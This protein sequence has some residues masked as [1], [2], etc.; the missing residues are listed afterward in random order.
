[1]TSLATGSDMGGSIRMPAALS[2]LYGYHPPYGRNPGTIADA[3]LVHA[4]AGPLARNFGDLVLLQNA[5]AGPLDGSPAIEPVLH[6]P[7]RYPSIKGWKIAV[8]LDQGWAEID[9]DVAAN[10]R[11]AVSLL[12]AAGAIVEEVELGLDMTA[13]DIR[14]AVEKALFSTSVGGELAAMAGQLRQ[15]TSY[16]VRFVK[17]AKRMTP[18]NAKEAA[19]AAER[20]HRAIEKAVFRKGYRALICPTTS[21]TSIAAD[22]DP[23]V[24]R[25]NINGARVDPYVGLMLTSIFNLLNWM[26]V[27][28]VPTGR[29]SNGVPTGMQIAARA[30]DDLTAATV[31]SAYS[32]RAEPWFK[33]TRVPD[34]S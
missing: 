31:A 30:Y 6:L 2:G 34:L 20:I 19:E 32:R 18:K 28:N 8:S 24:D 23:T 10:T 5:M 14:R 25:P 26:P 15:M 21:T 33:G 22:Y 9:P 13:A 12:E 11:A 27:I 1:M 4:S 16:G 7:Q 29:A 17:L 3:L